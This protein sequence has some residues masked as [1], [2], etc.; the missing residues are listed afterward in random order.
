MQSVGD[1]ARPATQMCVKIFV[2]PSQ[3]Q[4]NN[5]CLDWLKNSGLCRDQ[6]VSITNH[7][8]QAEEG[9]Q[10][11]LVFYREKSI[12]KNPVPCDVIQYVPSPGGTW[13]ELLEEA[14]EALAASAGA[15]VLALTRTAKNISDSNS[16]GVW[17]SKESGSGGELA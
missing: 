16:Q 6:I 12:H 10:C 8:S 14:S 2:E 9:D 3:V 4:T 17:F 5:K 1:S 13:D 15:D 7:E 11:L